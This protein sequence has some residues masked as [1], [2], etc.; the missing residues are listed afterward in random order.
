M[1]EMVILNYSIC[2][3]FSSFLIL[4]KSFTNACPEVPG[5]HCL[6]VYIYIKFVLYSPCV[7]NLMK[8]LI[9]KLYYILRKTTSQ[10]IY[11]HHKNQKNVGWK[12]IIS[13]YDKKSILY[14]GKMKVIF[15]WI[16]KIKESSMCRNVYIILIQK[17]WNNQEINMIYL[18]Y[19][20]RY[21]C[22]I[23]YWK[24]LS[25]YF[26]WLP[27][28]EHF[29]YL[30]SWYSIASLYICVRC[31]YQ[32]KYKII[33]ERSLGIF[34]EKLV[35]INKNDFVYVLSVCSQSSGSEEQEVRCSCDFS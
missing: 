10:K 15:A 11:Y 12:W 25:T 23:I 1:F 3:Q 18:Y 33:Y 34:G 26:P 16:T 8:N 24:F 32:I 30:W 17:I 4:F 13:I 22:K 19:R 27:S 7:E 31:I 14:L 21:L 6:K 9:Q 20:N 28:T 2:N 35:K 29:I 5:Y